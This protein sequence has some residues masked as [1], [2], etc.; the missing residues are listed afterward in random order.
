[1]PEHHKKLGGY[2]PARA[3]CDERVVSQPS[4]GNRAHGQGADLLV[5]P[6]LHRLALARAGPI[7]R[8]SRS[9]RPPALDRESSFD[10]ALGARHRRRPFLHSTP[11]VVLL[12]ALTTLNKES[13][14]SI[15]RV[16]FFWRKKKGIFVEVARFVVLLN[17]FSLFSFHFSFFFVDDLSSMIFRSKK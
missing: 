7:R 15:W 5:C 8:P 12:Q 3:A 9:L 1:M 14:T 2:G 17:Q 13:L 11:L 6:R 16:I 4:Q 10:R